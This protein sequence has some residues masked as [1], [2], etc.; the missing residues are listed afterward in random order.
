MM[1]IL[2]IRTAQLEDEFEPHKKLPTSE[3]LSEISE[4]DRSIYFALEI[5]IDRM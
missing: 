3:D 2:L 5:S 1:V 4:V